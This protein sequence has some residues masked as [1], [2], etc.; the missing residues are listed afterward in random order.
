MATG[1]AASLKSRKGVG[2]LEFSD[3]GRADGK[4]RVASTL[5]LAQTRFAVSDVRA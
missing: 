2:C 4:V 3:R 5:A 1:A